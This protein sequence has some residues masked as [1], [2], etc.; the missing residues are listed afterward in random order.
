M[1]LIEYTQ[2]QRLFRAFSF[3]LLIKIFVI[4]MVF[5]PNDKYF[6]TFI[7]QQSPYKKT[8]HQFYK[9]LHFFYHILGGVLS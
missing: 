2:S 5:P 7:L 8:H 4:W 6:N 1:V 3:E 9:N